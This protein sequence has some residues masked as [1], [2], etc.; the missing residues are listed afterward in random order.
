MVKKRPQRTCVGCKQI[1]TK[2][3]LI[4]VVRTPDGRAEVDRTGKQTGRGAYLCAHR[5]CW[6]R[7]LAQKQLNR[8]LKMTLTD[9]NTAQL[10]A[11]AES[12]PNLETGIEGVTGA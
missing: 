3:E 11:F 2:R 1:T 9:E 7:A 4:R 10:R 8:A 6:E 12:L 5:D